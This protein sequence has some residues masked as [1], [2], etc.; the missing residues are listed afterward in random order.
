MYLCTVGDRLYGVFSDAG[1]VVAQVSGRQAVGNWYEGGRGDRNEHQGSFRWTLS[2]DGQTLDGFYNRESQEKGMHK[3]KEERLGAPFPSDPSDEQ[4]MVPVRERIMGVYQG[5]VIGDNVP[6]VHYICSDRFQNV[7]GSSTSPNAW[8]E[9]W[10]FEDGTGFTGY[11]YTSDHKAGAYILRA[12]GNGKVA[13]FAW[14]GGIHR[15]NR[16]TVRKI[17]L[18]QEEFKT[19][20]SKCEEFG[21]G[22]AAIKGG[23]PSPPQSPNSKGNSLAASGIVLFIT[24]LAAFFAVVL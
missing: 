1:F 14:Y 10:A 5:D 13:G 9:G 4:C 21:P 19:T 12:I 3:W 17:V 6:G 18:D 24:A 2:E 22:F 23:E 7:Y 15:E 16:G 11:R 20:L 8:F